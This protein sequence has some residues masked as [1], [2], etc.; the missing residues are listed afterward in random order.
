MGVG[1]IGSEYGGYLAI[2]MMTNS[3]GGGDI[4][5]SALLKSPV[6][7]W[8]IHDTFETEKYLGPRNVTGNYW[9][10]QRVSLDDQTQYISADVSILVIHGMEDQVVR[11]VNTMKL[12]KDLTDNNFIF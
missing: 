5:S 6:I 11:V 7:D 9:N 12:T 10:Y 1:V 2:K 8:T 4:I 3:R